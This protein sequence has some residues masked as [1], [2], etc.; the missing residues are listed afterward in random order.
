MKKK[1]DWEI[2]LAYSLVIILLILISI[3]ITIGLMAMP[4]LIIASIIIIGLLNILDHG[5][6]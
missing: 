5:K 2:V 1:I 3:V 6:S 4:L